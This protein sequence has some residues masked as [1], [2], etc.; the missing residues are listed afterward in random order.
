MLQVY[1]IRHGE[2]AHE[3]TYKGHLD[4]PLAPEGRRRMEKTAKGL[5]GLLEGASLDAVYSSDLKRAVESAEIIARRFGIKKVGL[6]GAL[7]ERDFGLWEGMRY[8][9]IEKKFPADF[10]RW[11]KDP[12]KNTPTGGESTRRLALR[13]R[14]ALSEI[15]RSHADGERIAI[16]SHGGVTR[17]A[18]CHYLGI[19][20][21]RIFR[22]G[23]GFGC[24]N[25]VE[26]FGDTPVV[27]LVNWR[28]L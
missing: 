12:V 24:V 3:G 19:P 25:L 15:T 27:M 28:P 7:R 9:D 4:V 2:T 22:I 11:V 8:N 18:L 1:L 13:V 5:T 10:A 21:S 26:L 23:Q 16:V 20:L 6:N 14:R 17:V